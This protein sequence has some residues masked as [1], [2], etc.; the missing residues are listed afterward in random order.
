L[1]GGGRQAI[2][3]QWRILSRG[4]WVNI[5]Y[6][7]IGQFWIAPFAIIRLISIWEVDIGLTLEALTVVKVYIFNKRFSVFIMG[8]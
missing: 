2:V 6:F 5:C 7:N 4:K 3:G 8:P 1:A